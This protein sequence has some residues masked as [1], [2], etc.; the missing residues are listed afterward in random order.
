MVT[1]FVL[2]NAWACYRHIGS[3]KRE[4]LVAYSTWYMTVCCLLHATRIQY[5]ICALV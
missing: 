3:A 4:M 1:I 5:I 2:I